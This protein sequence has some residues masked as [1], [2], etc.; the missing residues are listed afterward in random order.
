MP[1]DT[2]YGIGVA[3]DARDGLPRLFAA[4]ERPLDKAIVLLLGDA[5]QAAIVG[6]WSPEARA[7]ADAFW[8]GGLTLVL[9]RRGGATLPPELTAGADT[10]GV[11]LP[12]HECPRFLARA[13]GPLPVTSANRSGSPAA[14]DAQGVIDQLGERIE[15]VL[16]GGPARGGVASTV[17]D[18]SGEEPRILRAGAIGAA[19]LQAALAAPW[20]GEGR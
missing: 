18:C 1:T 7:L 17:V 5:E 15:L 8:P 2:V 19:E 14:T 10:I 16:A 4:K 13:L 11:R 3:L 12:D 9:R 6:E 20:L